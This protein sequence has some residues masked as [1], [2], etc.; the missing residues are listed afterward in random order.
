MVLMSEFASGMMRD[1]YLHI[2]VV[3][4]CLHLAVYMWMDVRWN[5]GR[6][7]SCP[8][9]VGHILMVK[10]VTMMELRRLWQLHLLKV[11]C[12]VKVFV[13][14]VAWLSGSTLVLINEVTL[15]YTMP[16]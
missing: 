14:V 15:Q 16:H 4:L 9:I 2:C 7:S 13:T 11:I 1:V 8:V 6:N 10:H 12:I 5:A 3:R